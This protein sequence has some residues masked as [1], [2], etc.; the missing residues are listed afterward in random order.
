MT[1]VLAIHRYYWPDTPP[2]ASILRSIVRTWG[3]A[4]HDV[5][6]LASQPSYKPETRLAARPRTERV[7]EALVRRI[8]MAPDRSSRWRRPFNVV[9]F[10]V[11]V[12]ARILFGRRYDVVMCSTVPPVI[13]GWLVSLTATRRGARFVYHCMDLHPEIG[14]LSGEFSN[15]LVYRVLARLELSSCRRATAIVVLSEDMRAAVLARDASLEDRVVVLTN[16]E[17]PDFDAD[18]ETTAAPLHADP[19]VLRIVFTGNL[20]RFQGLEAITQAVLAE[21]PAL[22]GL[23]LVFMGEGAVKRELQL[24]V[25]SA[26]AATRR[27]VRFLPHGPAASARALLGTADLGLVSLTPDVIRYAFPSKVATYL[28]AGVPVLVAVEKDSELARTVVSAGAGRHLPTKDPQ[29]LGR[30]LLE[31]VADRHELAAMA[32]RAAELG[33]EEFSSERLLPRWSQLLSSVLGRARLVGS[34]S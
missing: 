29:A 28:G 30:V 15:P 19:A 23:Q 27:R 2:Y 20:G 13:L 11:A 24:L 18:P 33:R 14:R 12:A 22:D 6:V 16:F 5:D 4:G 3:E 26:P 7:D 10:P 31:L 9:W 1:R 8:D 32:E 34:S 17:L 25:D 21:V